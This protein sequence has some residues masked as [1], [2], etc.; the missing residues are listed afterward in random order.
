MWSFVDKFILFTNTIYIHE[1][2][3][4]RLKYIFETDQK[5]VSMLVCD[6]DV[7]KNWMLLHPVSSISPQYY[8]LFHL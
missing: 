2:V 4:A 6:L 3:P 1:R 7:V 5:H 8:L